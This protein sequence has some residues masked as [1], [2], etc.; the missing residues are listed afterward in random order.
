MLLDFFSGPRTKQVLKS[1]VTG[2]NDYEKEEY[3]TQPE[4]F[5]TLEKFA[6][7]IGV[8]GDTIVEWA[9]RF[10]A[11]S[12][13]YNAAKDLQKEFLMDNGLAG[14]YPPAAF[15]FVA[16]NVTNMRDKTEVEHSGG[17]SLTELFNGQKKNG[18][19]KQY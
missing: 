18:D 2:K 5:P 15:I 6:R 14:H 17:I 1:V 7:K 13:A 8:N 3:E 11:F 19:T 4:D 10:P 9:K 16:K 12:A